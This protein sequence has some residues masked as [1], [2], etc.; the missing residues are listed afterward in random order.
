MKI[1]NFGAGPAKLPLEVLQRVQREMLDWCGTGMSV[2]EVSHRSKEYDLLIAQA[3]AN[4]RKLLSIPDNYRVLF[5][6]GG[7]TTQFSAVPLNLLGGDAN[8]GADY[9]V[10]GTWSEKAAAEARRYSSDIK[11]IVSTKASGYRS[12]PLQ[13]WPV[14]AE[15]KYVYLCT[16]ETVNGVEF[17][18]PVPGT[19][20]IPIVAD[21]SSNL[22]SRPIDVSQYGL[23]YAGAQKNIGPAGVTLVIV[24]EDLMGH[25]HP[26]TPL[27]LDYATAAANRSMYN[28]PPTFAIYVANCVFEWLLAHGGL[29]WIDEMNATKATALYECIDRSGGFYECPVEPSSRSRMNVVFRIRKRELEPTFVSESKSRGFVQLEGHRSVGGLRASLYNAVTLEETQALINCM[30]DFRER[31]AV[32]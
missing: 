21:M 6:Q 30:N 23:I 24:R 13:P 2:M 28:T 11:E 31:H 4:I 16:N 25:A 27:M 26:L 9:I 12:I 22:L 3:E 20:G 19:L 14:R 8:A 15:S 29:P 17:N 7:G 32:D 18:L 10:T 5:L 1:F